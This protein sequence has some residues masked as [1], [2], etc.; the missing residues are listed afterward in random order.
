VA[1]GEE[2]I[3]NSRYLASIVLAC[4]AGLGASPTTAQESPRLLFEVTVNDS[5]VARPEITV[6]SGGEGRI[7]LGEKH[8]IF[9][10]TIRG[11][12][13]AVAFDV[14]DGERRLKPTLVI[15]KTV[16]GSIEWLSPSE[17][18]SVRLAVSWVE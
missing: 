2:S 17:G 4:L 1:I 11:D 16:P 15:T 14:A 7:D 12:D 5:V 8:V 6:R 3:M 9:V 13:L 18:Q 10:P